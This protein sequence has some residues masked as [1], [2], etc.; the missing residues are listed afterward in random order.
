M[1]DNLRRML[2]NFGQVRPVP[3]PQARAAD[4]SHETQYMTGRLRDASP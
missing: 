2:G 1:L 4:R 3:L